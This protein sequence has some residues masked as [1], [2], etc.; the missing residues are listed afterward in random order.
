VVLNELLASNIHGIVD[1]AGEHED[2][3]EI[4]NVSP[5]AVTL[6]GMYLSDRS[7]NLT[8]WQFPAGLVVQPG[9]KVLVWADED[10]AQGPTHANFKMSSTNGEEVLLTAS[11]GT[12]VVDRISFG[13]QADDVSLGRFADGSAVWVTFPEPSPLA[14]NTPAGC[15]AQRYSGADPFAYPVAASVAGTPRV[16]A[17]F[18]L[19]FRSGPA[20]TPHGIVAGFGA[21]HLA[22]PFSASRLLVALPLVD[23]VTVSADGAGAIN[24]AV[25]VP[26]NAS[27]A[28]LTVGF[29]AWTIQGTALVG[30]SAV[31]LRLCP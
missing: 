13:P 29:Q 10:Q 31:M 22:L 14:S 4:A 1:E 24:L 30:S 9:Q 12:T 16:G 25:P 20:N 8:K 26:A 27:L 18:T 11:N 2:W 17:A 28:G 15:G 21:E 19:Q 23:V 7:T 6:G 3:I 5:Q